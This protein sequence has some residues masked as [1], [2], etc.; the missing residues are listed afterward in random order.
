MSESRAR[1]QPVG[2]QQ[3]KQPGYTQPHGDKG[4]LIP[5]ARQRHTD[6]LTTLKMSCADTGVFEKPCR[7]LKS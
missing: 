1:V 3:L 4:H 2:T 5:H 7:F 6:T